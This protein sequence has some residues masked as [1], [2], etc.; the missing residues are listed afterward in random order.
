[1]LKLQRKLNRTVGKEQY[2]KWYVPVTPDLI[3]DLGWEKGDSLTAKV[4]KGKLVVE[5]E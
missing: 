4:S 2:F 3:E 1:M 5:K